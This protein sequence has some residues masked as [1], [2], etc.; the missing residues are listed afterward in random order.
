ME[1]NEENVNPICKRGQ[2]WKLGEHYLMCGDS[3][4]K[5][6]VEKLIKVGECPLCNRFSCDRPAI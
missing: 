2:V 6:E 1:K 5:E 4:R 3:T